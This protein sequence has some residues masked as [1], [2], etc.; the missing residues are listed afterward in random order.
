MVTTEK[1][2]IG[3]YK[4]VKICKVSRRQE[5]LESGLAFEEAL[6]AVSRYL[7]NNSMVIFYK[8]FDAD[9]YYI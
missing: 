2:Y 8:E 5:V 4:V 3:T 9:E 6:R 1:K 7:N